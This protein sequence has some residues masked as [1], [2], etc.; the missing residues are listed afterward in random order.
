MIRR[1]NN[2]S[3]CIGVHW[4]KAQHMWVSKVTY[5]GYSLFLGQYRDFDDAVLIRE[6][7]EM[8]ILMCKNLKVDNI[9]VLERNIIRIILRVIISK[10]DIDITIYKPRTNIDGTE[11]GDL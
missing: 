4:N 11:G 2:Y 8:V 10:N 3:G 1:V 6:K 5:K 9:Q 7:A